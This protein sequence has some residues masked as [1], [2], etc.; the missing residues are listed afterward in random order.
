MAKTKRLRRAK[1]E[2]KHGKARSTC[3]SGKDA[4]PTKKECKP[5]QR[6]NLADFEDPDKP[7]LWMRVALW[8]MAATAF[9]AAAWMA[10][11]PKQVTLEEAEAIMEERQ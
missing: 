6:V 5:A 9:A 1:A 4:N 8:L 10:L 3:P 11:G 7:P 2:K